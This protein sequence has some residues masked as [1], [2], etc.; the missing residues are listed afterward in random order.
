ML[1]LMTILIHTPLWVWA[2]LL[3]LLYKGMQQTSTRPIKLWQLYIFPAVFSPFILISTI[4]ATQPLIAISG[5]VIG[6]ILGLFLGYLLWKD[7]SLISQQNGQW[8][9]R[10]SYI[11]LLLYLFIFV[12]RYIISVMQ[13]LQ[14]TIIQTE[15]FNLL[16]GL[17]TG[18]GLGLLIAIPLLPK[19]TY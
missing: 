7:N 9:Q 14:T 5:L 2:I 15:L 16:I 13:H 1:K 12:F 3:F 6:L 17:P 18:L 11:P 8:Q 4:N 19:Q 10:G